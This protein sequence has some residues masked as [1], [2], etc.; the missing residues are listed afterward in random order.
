MGA[1]HF[2]VPSRKAG[3]GDNDVTPNGHCFVSGKFLETRPA[4]LVLVTNWMADLTVENSPRS[5]G[6]R[7][8]RGCGVN[9]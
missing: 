4:P 8:L 1:E 9:H 3:V 2:L 6:A 5:G 7:L